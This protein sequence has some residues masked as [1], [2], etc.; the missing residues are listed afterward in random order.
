MRRRHRAG[1]QERRWSAEAGNTSAKV[2]VGG[3]WRSTDL[4]TIAPRRSWSEIF[5]SQ[6]R[7]S[8]SAVQI[9]FGI[10]VLARQTGAAQA[11]NFPN[12]G[13]R[14]ML[15]QQLCGQPEIDDAPIGLREALQNSPTLKPALIDRRRAILRDAGVWWRSRRELLRCGNRRTRRIHRRHLLG[16]KRKPFVSGI[17]RFCAAEARIGSACRIWIVG[18]TPVSAH[19]AGLR[20]LKPAKR[21]R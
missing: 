9:V 18:A 1:E 12:L 2:Q 20:L 13:R 17:K 5:P 7:S 3:Y 21:P 8:Q 10:A 15:G 11:Q 16:V 19:M 6:S 4:L 14:C